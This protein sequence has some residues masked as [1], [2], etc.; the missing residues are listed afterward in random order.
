MWK[1]GFLITFFLFQSC[2][3]SARG[4]TTAPVDVS[5]RSVFAS[6]GR[7]SSEP[8]SSPLDNSRLNTLNVNRQRV[9]GL[10]RNFTGPNKNKPKPATVTDNWHSA[11]NIWLVKTC[12]QRQIMLLS[13]LSILICSNHIWKVLIM[14]YNKNYDTE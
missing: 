12:F 3:V 8:L 4:F 2:V 13:S 7:G 14:S 6:R 9:R 10:I 1:I 5:D 11:I